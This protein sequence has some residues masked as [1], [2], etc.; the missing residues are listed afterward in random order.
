M[1]PT[2]KY[3]KTENFIYRKFYLYLD[4]CGV[5]VSIFKKIFYK[6]YE[7]YDAYLDHGDSFFLA[8]TN[9]STIL[10]G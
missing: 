9:S 10:V 5:S 7:K 1:D 2:T 8:T 6:I 4:F 3:N